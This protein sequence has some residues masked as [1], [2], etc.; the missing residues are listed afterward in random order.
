MPLFTFGIIFVSWNHM[1]VIK[2]WY[3]RIPL[4]LLLWIAA[5]AAIFSIQPYDTAAFSLCPL[6]MLGIEGCPGCGLGRAMN[7][8]ARGEFLASWSLHPLAGLA[9]VAIIH[10]IWTLSKQVKNTTHYG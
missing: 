6:D 1:N 10:R 4:E 9:Y 5:L 3:A 2:Q 7:L 8:L